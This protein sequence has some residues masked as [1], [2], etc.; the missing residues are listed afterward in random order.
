MV[1]RGQWGLV[2]FSLHGNLELVY[3][4]K[5]KV[6]FL[7]T[8]SLLVDPAYRFHLQLPYNELIVAGVRRWRIMAQPSAWI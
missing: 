5:V 6:A 7:G 8:V 1:D 4:V 3:V 2:S